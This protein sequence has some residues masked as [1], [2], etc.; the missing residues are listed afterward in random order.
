[1]TDKPDLLKSM[2]IK[3]RM[4]PE[5]PGPAGPG[6][7]KPQPQIRKAKTEVGKASKAA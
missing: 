7:Q 3:Q 6:T 2:F 5:P 1:M 4:R